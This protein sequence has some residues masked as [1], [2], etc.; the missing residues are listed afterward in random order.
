MDLKALFD[1]SYGLYVVCS[2]SDEKLNGQI[3]NTVFQVTAEPPRVAVSI[4]KNNLTHQ[5]I[6]NSG[7]FS[8]SV[9]DVSTPMEFIGLF[10]FKSGRDVDKLSQVRYEKGITGCPCVTDNALSMVE[11]KVIGQLDAGS[12]T[13]FVGEVVSARILQGGNPLT[14][15]DYHRVKK[16]KAPKNAPTY[17]DGVE[18]KEER[19]EAA[20]TGMKKYI[21]D[22]CGYVYDPAQGDP[23]HGVT[24]GTAFEDI[25]DDWVCP[26]CGAGKDQF[27]PQD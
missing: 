12:H 25:P 16:G 2:H 15:A 7:V 4:S 3:A 11:T 6:S 22:V 10:G 21:C 23:E 5:Y 19:P 8:F 24:A 1:L 26:V 18:E 17:R 20:G 27:S 13:I 9:L 14:Y